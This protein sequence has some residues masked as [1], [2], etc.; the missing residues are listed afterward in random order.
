MKNKTLFSLGIVFFFFE[1]CRNVKHLKK[2]ETLYK[3]IIFSSQEP[4]PGG[5]REILSQLNYK[6]NKNLISLRNFGIIKHQ[7]FFYNMFYKRNTTKNKKTIGEPPV[8]FTEQ[9]MSELSKDLNNILF[10]D[11][12]LDNSITHSS[13]TKRKQTTIHFDIQLGTR[14][15][16]RKIKYESSNSIVHE[17]INN[18]NT[19]IPKLI[20]NQYYEELKVESEIS[21]I[22]KTLKQYGYYALKG[23]NVEVIADTSDI[24]GLLDITF[25]VKDDLKNIALTRYTVDSVIISQKRNEKSKNIELVKPYNYYFQGETSPY[26]LEIL[27]N[28]ITIRKTEFF[29]IKDIRKTYRGLTLM[30]AFK[31]IT[32]ESYIQDTTKGLVNFNIALENKKKYGITANVRAKRRSET[33]GLA[34]DFEFESRNVFRT[35]SLLSINFSGVLE[36]QVAT[37]EENLWETYGY[38][39]DISLEIPKL[40][41]SPFRKE[42]IYTNYSARTVFLAGY[43]AFNRI[44]YNRKRVSFHFGYKIISKKTNFR[45][46]IN[47]FDVGYSQVS[48][49]NDFQEF[50]ENTNDKLAIESYKS[51]MSVG[52]GYF[53]TYQKSLKNHSRFY[54]QFRLENNGD[55]LGALQSFSTENNGTHEIFDVPYTQNVTGEVVVRKHWYRRK[56]GLATKISLGLGKPYGN[57]KSLPI[58]NSFYISGSNDIRAFLSRTLGPGGTKSTFS[59]HESTGEMKL[60]G[61]AELRFDLLGKLKGALFADAGNIWLL[62]EDKNRP[63]GK[64]QFSTFLETIALGTGFGLR[65][66]IDFLALR[67]DF[68]S[69]LYDPSEVLEENKWS[70]FSPP[71]TQFWVELSFLNSL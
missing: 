6:P 23:S 45:H 67:F 66:D 3:K 68:S 54:F 24:K 37:T 14:Y 9:E 31:N 15:K 17:L 40:L 38:G 35:L 53:V 71:Y 43:N 4:L 59:S 32:I 2:D 48:L 39:G 11:G 36:A 8:I 56:T 28:Q 41:L 60:V 30:R 27:S 44:N 7:L 65:Y 50:I 62:Q 47:F 61:N 34:T 55:V 46:T 18:K 29:D 51:N 57:S 16:I 26:K 20:P 25:S 42:K 5:R 19:F 64:F 52:I 58:R 63:N 10:K 21:N 49:S 69:P 12:Y 13:K 22:Q 33:Y 70:F 1:S